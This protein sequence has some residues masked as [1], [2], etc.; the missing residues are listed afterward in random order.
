MLFLQNWINIHKKVNITI[1]TFTQNLYKIHDL[2]Q[3]IYN[4]IQLIYN[5]INKY[6]NTSNTFN[7]IISPLSSILDY[8]QY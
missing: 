4:L 6:H 3:F 7:T 1:N 2:K 5:I 8:D